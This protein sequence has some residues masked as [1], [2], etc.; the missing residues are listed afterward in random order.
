MILAAGVGSRL[1][2]LTKTTPKCLMDINGQPMLRIVSKR[3]AQAGVK[4]VIINIHHHAE[5]VRSYAASHLAE[6]FDEVEFSFEPELLGTGGG[7]KAVAPFFASEQSFLLVNA[8]IYCSYS[9]TN[10]LKPMKSEVM[11]C[12]A[13]MDREDHSLLEFDS[14]GNFCGWR[15]LKSTELASKQPLGVLSK[16]SAF[17]GLQALSP[18][19]FDYL[20]RDTRKTFS[21]IDTYLD[22][23]KAGE[24]IIGVDIGKDSVWIDMGTPEQLAKVR[25]V[26]KEIRK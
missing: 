20:A 2:E 11:G 19:I 3:L 14:V 4:K 22:A 26:D 10:L 21:I 15:T 24:R 5:Q 12:L 1:K 13:L 25:E 9:L 6:F 7:L 16:V 17:C 23:A 18:R 8:D